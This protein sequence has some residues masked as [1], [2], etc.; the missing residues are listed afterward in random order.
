MSLSGD[1]G[2]VELGIPRGREAGLLHPAV[3]V[4]GQRVLDAHPTVLQVV[5]LTSTIRRFPS[6]VVIDPDPRWQTTT[7]AVAKGIEALAEEHGRAASSGHPRVSGSDGGCSADADG[8]RQ[9]VDAAAEEGFRLADAPL[10]VAE[11]L[12]AHQSVDARPDQHPLGGK[13]GG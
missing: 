2:E 9:G 12:E 8:G 6:E 11:E 4:T 3:V 5:P 13:L 7:V 1:V 10:E